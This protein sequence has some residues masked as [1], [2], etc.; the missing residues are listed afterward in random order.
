MKLIFEI[1]TMKLLVLTKAVLVKWQEYIHLRTV[2][3][4]SNNER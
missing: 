1:E 3:E 4:F 2:N